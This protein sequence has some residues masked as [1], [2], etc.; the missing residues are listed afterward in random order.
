VPVD[1]PLYA[2]ASPLGAPE[3]IPAVDSIPPVRG[4]SDE[5]WRNVLI[6]NF[7]AELWAVSLL[8][9][10]KGV[11]CNKRHCDWLLVFEPV[12]LEALGFDPQVIMSALTF[13]ATLSQYRR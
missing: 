8:R 4:P 7:T 11:P 6:I 12:L 1:R 2:C 10:V 3:S 9:Q 13:P 5:C